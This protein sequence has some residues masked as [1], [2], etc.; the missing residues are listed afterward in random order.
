ME[1]RRGM[2]AEIVA[3]V[4]RDH[5]HG[6]TKT[7]NRSCGVGIVSRISAAQSTALV[8]TTIKRASFGPLTV[9]TKDID[10]HAPRIVAIAAGVNRPA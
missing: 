2:S 10:L 9:V 4:Q 5:G 6:P 8:V 1:M 3:S 7:P